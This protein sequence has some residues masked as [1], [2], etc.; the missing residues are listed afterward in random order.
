[1]KKFVD[2][3]YSM[4]GLVIVLGMVG[5]VIWAIAS[6]AKAFGIFVGVRQ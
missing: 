1:M 2:Y 3:L 4:L 5:G 6:V